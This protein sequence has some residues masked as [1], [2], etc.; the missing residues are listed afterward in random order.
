MLRGCRKAAP[1]QQRPRPTRRGA[2]AQ[3]CSSRC[4]AT[5]PAPAATPLERPFGIWQLVCNYM[6]VI[7]SVASVFPCGASASYF[8]CFF[9]MLFG[10]GNHLGNLLHH[11]ADNCIYPELRAFQTFG[12]VILRLWHAEAV[13]ARHNCCERRW[14]EEL[15]VGS[16]P[17][18][19]WS[20]RF[21]PVFKSG[22]I[23][24][25]RHQYRAVSR[26]PRSLNFN[27]LLRNLTEPEQ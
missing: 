19:V 20:C 23:C 13:Y 22:H 3:R 24:N 2:S 25:I 6:Q 16:N 11:F 8:A 9:K 14:G 15:I 26:C 21:Y 12:I 5:P 7:V 1:G 4:L 27:R 18:C 10:Y 17:E